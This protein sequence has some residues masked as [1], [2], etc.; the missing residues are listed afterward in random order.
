MQSGNWT[1]V[2][3]ESWNLRIKNEWINDIHTCLNVLSSEV[4]NNA[5]NNLRVFLIRLLKKFTVRLIC[6]GTKIFL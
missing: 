4:K 1:I 3:P 2:E 6:Q 5:I